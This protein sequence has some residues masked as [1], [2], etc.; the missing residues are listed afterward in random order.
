MQGLKEPGT[1]Y[2]KRLSDYLREDPSLAEKITYEE[3]QHG[4]G[5]PDD[6]D[7]PFE[8]AYRVYHRI[9]TGS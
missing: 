9:S 6:M 2:K 1:V 5:L 7:M 3:F 8:R 4:K